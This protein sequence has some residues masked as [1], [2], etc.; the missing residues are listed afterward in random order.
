MFHLS[1]Q[2]PSYIEHKVHPQSLYICH[3]QV[4]CIFHRLIYKTTCRRDIFVLLVKLFY[5]LV[6]LWHKILIEVCNC[7]R[8]LYMCRW[9]KGRNFGHSNKILLGA[10]CNLTCIACNF[11]ESQKPYSTNLCTCPA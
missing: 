9:S 8:N 1:T 4:A 5:I 7:L 11:L 2:T 10:E 6:I 3:F